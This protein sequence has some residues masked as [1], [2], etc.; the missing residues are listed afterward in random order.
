MTILTPTAT[1]Q[2]DHATALLTRPIGNKIAR[3]Y[4]TKKLPKSYT[5][6]SELSKLNALTNIDSEDFQALS[7]FQKDK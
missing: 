7:D 4:L 2:Y 5:T 1:T 6:L 3:V